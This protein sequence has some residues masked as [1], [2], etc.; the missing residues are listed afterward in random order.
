MNAHSITGG[1]ACM[2]SDFAE[3]LRNSQ[4]MT[5]RRE[6]KQQLVF[7]TVEE[8]LIESCDLSQQSSL[9]HDRW[10]WSDSVNSEQLFQDRTGMG[11]PRS[12]RN[13]PPGVINS[14]VMRVAPACC[15][16]LPEQRELHCEFFGHPQII[17]IEKGD[18][19]TYR[20]CQ[21]LISQPGGIATML[22]RDDAYSGISEAGKVTERAIAGAV[23][24]DDEFPIGE[25]LIEHRLHCGLQ[26]GLPVIGRQDH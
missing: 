25:G 13:R 21:R 26:V 4:G 24:N 10:H 15:L 6:P 1:I 23:I 12:T 20:A 16:V 3:P 11:R 9:N 17:R 5:H 18:I 22:A 7:L 19:I 8:R 14:L 2:G